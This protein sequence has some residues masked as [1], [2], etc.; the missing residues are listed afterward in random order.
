MGADGRCSMSMSA[1][2]FSGCPEMYGRMQNRIATDVMDAWQEHS[3]MG[4]IFFPKEKKW[5]LGVEDSCP[6]IKKNSE[7]PRFITMPPFPLQLQFHAIHN[8]SYLGLPRLRVVCTPLKS[9]TAITGCVGRAVCCYEV[10]GPSEDRQL[11]RR[12]KVRFSWDLLF[13]LRSLYSECDL[14]VVSL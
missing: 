6:S 7:V 12:K 10:V 9:K 11:C 2:G 13:T 5:I 3:L 8:Y 4:P 1:A 14:T